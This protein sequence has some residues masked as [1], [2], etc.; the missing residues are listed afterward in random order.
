MEQR[1]ER[2]NSL[3]KRMDTALSRP[4][5]SP[6]KRAAAERVKAGAQALLEHRKASYPSPEPTEPK[7]ESPPVRPPNSSVET[8]DDEARE[9]TLGGRRTREPYQIG[10]LYAVPCFM[11]SFFVCSLAYSVLPHMW[12]LRDVVM[13]LLPVLMTIYMVNA[14][15]KHK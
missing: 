6:E 13:T 7:A 3:V 15:E 12:G 4:E 14:I 8:M 9:P 2:L 5:L 11:A 1:I 10:W